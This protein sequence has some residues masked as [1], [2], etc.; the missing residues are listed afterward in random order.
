MPAVS[1]ENTIESH[2]CGMLEHSRLSQADYDTLSKLFEKDKQA[3]DHAI[4]GNVA[5]AAHSLHHSQLQRQLQAVSRVFNIPEL[6]TMI[7]AQLLSQDPVEAFLSY[8]KL[9]NMP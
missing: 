9:S 1:H 3:V 7:L 6:L 2:L 8:A 4:P 5:I